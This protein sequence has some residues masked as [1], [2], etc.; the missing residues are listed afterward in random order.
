MP[1]G[2]PWRAR[3]HEIPTFGL[4]H[5]G[6]VWF[7]RCEQNHQENNLYEIRLQ[8][9]SPKILNRTGNLAVEVFDTYGVLVGYQLATLAKKNLRKAEEWKNMFWQQNLLRQEQRSWIATVGHQLKFIESLRYSKWGNALGSFASIKYVRAL[10][11]DSV[12]P[13]SQ[14]IRCRSRWC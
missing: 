9:T 14:S 10:D 5:Q 13:W 3:M 12:V 8:W 4:T 11:L 2:S 1:A 7:L 6:C